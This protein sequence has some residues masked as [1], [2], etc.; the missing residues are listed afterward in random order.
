LQR[1]SARL[2]QPA[3]MDP[4]GEAGGCPGFYIVFLF[5]VY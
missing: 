2:P 5:Y 4:I 3:L 1:I